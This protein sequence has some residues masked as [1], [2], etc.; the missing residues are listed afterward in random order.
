MKSAIKLFGIIAVVAVFAFSMTACS[1][2]LDEPKVLVIKGLDAAGYTNQDMTI[3]LVSSND[4]SKVQSITAS[5]IT[6][7]ANNITVSLLNNK[8]T[9]S[10]NGFNYSANSADK[11]T[12]S[13]SY[14]VILF[15]GGLG[16][17]NFSKVFVSRNQVEFKRATTTINFSNSTFLML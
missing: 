5:A 2:E 10:G 8:G 4:F 3:L 11:W 6:A 13:G 15:D 12:D 9:I 7:R 17:V 14:Y 1:S 16:T